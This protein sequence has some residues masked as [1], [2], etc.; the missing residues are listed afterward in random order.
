MGRCLVVVSPVSFYGGREAVAGAA[1]RF[2]KDFSRED[3][4][5]KTPPSEKAP[6]VKSVK[7]MTSPAEIKLYKT[8]ARAGD[9]AAQ[10]WLGLIYQK[11]D[12][13][14][15][16]FSEAIKWY[17]MAAEQGHPEAQLRLDHLKKSVR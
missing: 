1:A 16:D 2:K 11:G 7:K 9:V 15:Q 12:G 8:L 14:P 3:F 13:V 17:A 10:N 5:D 4:F 6:R